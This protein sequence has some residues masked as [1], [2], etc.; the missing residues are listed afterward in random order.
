M[1]ALSNGLFV[2]KLSDGRV[3][4]VWADYSLETT[5]NKALKGTG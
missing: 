3:N 4:G 5:Q 2:A 1:S